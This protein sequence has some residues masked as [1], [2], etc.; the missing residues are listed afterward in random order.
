LQDTKLVF[1][2]WFYYT[3]LGH[4]KLKSKEQWTN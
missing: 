2:T 3:I 1:F 4:K